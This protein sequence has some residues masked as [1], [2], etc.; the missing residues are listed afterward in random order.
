MCINLIKLQGK[1]INEVYKVKRTSEQYVGLIEDILEDYNNVYKEYS[2]LVGLYLNDKII[3][4]VVM[5]NKQ[6]NGKYSFTDLIIDEE[7][8]GKGYGLLST[9]KI[10]E[11]FRK[12]NQSKII[13]IEVFNENLK[14]IKCYEKCGFMITK[15][16]SWNSNFVEME[17]EL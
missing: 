10:I 17:F 11:S 16:C 14:A 13:K 9:Q 15:P 1:E 5:A 3:G 6:L 4:L 7:Y 12:M 8:Q 2:D